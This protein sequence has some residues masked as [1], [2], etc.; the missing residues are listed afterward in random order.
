[1]EIAIF[2]HI[3]IFSVRLWE[4]ILESPLSL[5]TIALTIIGGAYLFGRYHACAQKDKEF[6]EK[7]LEYNAKYNE[8]ERQ[9]CQE[10]KH[11]EY[12]YRQELRDRDRSVDEWKEK[13]FQSLIERTETNGRSP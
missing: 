11:L 5:I 13:Y 9:Y 6:A 3:G 4:N 10:M 2:H 1:M 7:A 8:L 12:Q